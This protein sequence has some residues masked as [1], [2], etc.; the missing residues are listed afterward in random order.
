MTYTGQNLELY[1][2]KDRVIE[3]AVK[4]GYGA[5]LNIT[6]SDFTW[7]VYK[8]TIGTI[9]LSKTTISGIELTIPASGIME[10]T[11]IPEDTVSLLGQYNHECEI[12]TPSGKQDTIFTGY[13]KI[14]DSKT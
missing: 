6:G 10:I 1:R 11:L 7:V 12:T 5:C 14:I 3:V 13:F 2:G 8:P 4:D 9:V